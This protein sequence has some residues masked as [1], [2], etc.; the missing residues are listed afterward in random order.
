MLGFGS[1]CGQWLWSRSCFKILYELAPDSRQKILTLFVGFFFF[2]FTL[3]L[4]FISC[5]LSFWLGWCQKD[6]ALVLTLGFFFPVS[7][8]VFDCLRYDKENKTGV[9]KGYFLWLIIGYG[10]GKY[11]SIVVYIIIIPLYITSLLFLTYFVLNHKLFNFR[12]YRL[13]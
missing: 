6:V 3:C 11:L 1:C 12:I 2:G 8:S 4:G 5:F 10:F 13:F 7:L 9:V